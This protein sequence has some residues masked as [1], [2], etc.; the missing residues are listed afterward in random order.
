MLP[1]LDT[2]D[3]GTCRSRLLLS[4]IIKLRRPIRMHPYTQL[5]QVERLIITDFLERVNL[6]ILKN[7][8]SEYILIGLYKS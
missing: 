7:I 3:L 5:S 4:W 2:S 1:N 8:S 6:M